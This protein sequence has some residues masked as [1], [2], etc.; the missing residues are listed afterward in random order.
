MRLLLLAVPLLA[1]PLLAACTQPAAPAVAPSPS[2]ES[3][4]SSDAPPKGSVAGGSLAPVEVKKALQTR[5]DEIRACYHALLE[6]NNK[7]SGK[8]VL[9]FTIDESGAVEETVVLNETTL[10]NET[11]QCIADEV[12]KIA[13]PK[14]QGGKARITYPWEFTAE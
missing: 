14:P 13:F 12:K 5:R 1:V 6:K 9:R 7:A 2:P 11:A 4:G 3:T 8:V 10:P